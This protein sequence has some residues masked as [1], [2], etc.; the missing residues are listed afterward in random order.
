MYKGSYLGAGYV[1]FITQGIFLVKASLVLEV[2]IELEKSM[3][4]QRTY[5]HIHVFCVV[6]YLLIFNEEIAMLMK[7]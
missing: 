3:K 2:C 4:Y 1:R 7:K 6:T 5:I